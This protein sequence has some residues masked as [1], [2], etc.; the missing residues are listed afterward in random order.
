MISISR[1]K[2][3]ETLLAARQRRLPRAGAVY[4]EHGP[5]HEALTKELE[6]YDVTGVKQT[7]F[8]RQFKKCAWCERRQRFSS[9]P[10]EHVRPKDGAIRTLPG[11]VPQQRDPHVYWWL[12]WSWE[13]L[14]FSC[15][16]CNDQGHK[17]NYFPLAP[18]SE[19]P[20]PPYPLPNPLPE[21]LVDLSREQ[22]LLVDPSQEDPLE[23]VRW[24]P[25][26][27]HLARRLWIWSPQALTERGRVTIAVFR[28]T[29]L[30]DD[31]QHH[32]CHHVLPLIVQ[33]EEHERAGRRPAAQQVWG[34]A[35]ELLSPGCDFTAATWCALQKW[36]PD[37]QRR[38]WELSALVRPGAA[39]PGR[40]V[41]S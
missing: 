6:G 5:G 14:V 16:T 7:L 30:A 23:H 4:D 33:L 2:P 39:S 41:G 29:E 19:A 40:S 17:G 15:V 26:N 13:N 12:T 34:Q 24:V 20:R 8:D 11:V 21:P 31:I 9:N 27:T 36:L 32:L 35:Q 28:L 38:Q 1:G 18:G 10:I 3:P 37:D 22:A 25:G